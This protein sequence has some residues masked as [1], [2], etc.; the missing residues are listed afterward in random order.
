MPAMYVFRDD[1]G[2]RISNKRAVV[3]VLGNLEPNAGDE[4]GVVPI[5]SVEDFALVEN[6]RFALTFLVGLDGL[7]PSLTSFVVV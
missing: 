1:V 4:T 5:A 2:G 6:D 7:L 3:F